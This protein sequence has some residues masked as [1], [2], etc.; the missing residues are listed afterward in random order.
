[1]IS[2]IFFKLLYSGYILLTSSKEENRQ[3]ALVFNIFICQKKIMT[4]L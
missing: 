4:F 3:C 1:M 2:L